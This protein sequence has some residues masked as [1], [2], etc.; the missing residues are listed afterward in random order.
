MNTTCE[1]RSVRLRPLWLAL[2]SLA[3][4]A[5]G[6]LAFTLPLYLT[7]GILLM[8]AAGV[9]AVLL[10]T[11]KAAVCLPVGLALLALLYFLGG[12][13]LF[14]PLLGVLALIMAYVLTRC[15]RQ[16]G[17]KSGTT[18]ALTVAFLIGALVIAAVLYGSAGNS[19]DPKEI[20]KA[21]DKALSVP[22]NALLEVTEQYFD[23]LTEAERLTIAP[24]PGDFEKLR[25]NALAGVESLIETFRILLPGLIIAA[26]QILS[27]IAVCFFVLTAKCAMLYALLPETKWVLYPTQ[28]TCVIYKVALLLFVVVSF[29]PSVGAI[30]LVIIS[31]LVILT[32][33]MAAC[34]IRGIVVRLRHPML[35]RKM[36]VFL[37]IFLAVSLITLGVFLPICSIFLAFLGANDVS[38]LRSAE[39][40]QKD[41]AKKQ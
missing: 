39:A 38:S 12:E 36:T 7:G 31:L 8:C 24:K 23:S 9:F 34:G 2:C 17:T 16:K 40:Q 4:A 21:I 3:L 13:T 5:L 10:S 30:A 28:I 41:K 32:P 20:G 18:V 1:S 14:P 11:V 29:L 35:R 22:K 33:S 15:V 37:I 25:E 19:F 26:A 27:Y 6:A